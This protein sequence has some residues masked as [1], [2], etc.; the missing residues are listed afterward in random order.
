M[1]TILGTKL[2]MSQIFSEDARALPVTVIKA[3]PCRVVQVK[4][5][6]T[7]GYEAVQLALEV[8]KPAKVGKALAGHFAKAGVAPSPHLVETLVD[9]S[10]AFQPGSTIN[11]D[12]IFEPGVRADVTGVSRGKGFA[13]VMKRHNFSGLC[14]SHGTHKKHRAGGSI[15]ACAT[16]SRV[17]KGKSMPGRMGLRAHHCF[18]H[19]SG[20]GIGRRRAF[21]AEGSGTRTQGRIGDGAKGGQGRW[22]N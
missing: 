13:G 3:G 1:N 9:D 4:T 21:A 10:G 19:R 14:A 2:G 5:A 7:D 8:G 6:E 16:P 20:E 15:G 22:M 11:V 12:E 17:F 18:E